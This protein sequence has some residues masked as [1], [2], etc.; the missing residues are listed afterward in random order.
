MLWST[1]ARGKPDK[2]FCSCYLNFEKEKFGKEVTT[3]LFS[4]WDFELINLAFKITLNQFA[5]LKEKIMQNNNQSFMTK[6]LL[7]LLWRYLNYKKGNSGKKSW[8]LVWFKSSQK[9]SM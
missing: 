5:C 8:K 9:P 7:E 2:T 4:V 3:Q 6:P 1:F